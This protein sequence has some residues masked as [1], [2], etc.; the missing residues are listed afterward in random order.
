ME[1]ALDANPANRTAVHLAASW[2]IRDQD[3][4]FAIEAL[5]NFVSHV[6]CDEEMSLL[7]IHLFCVR[8]QIVEAS[9]ELERLLLWDPTN[10]KLLQ[11]EQEIRNA[12]RK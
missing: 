9:L 12:K 8:N 10:E 1:N 2:A 3:Y 11:I 4:T 6:D 5:E 7:L